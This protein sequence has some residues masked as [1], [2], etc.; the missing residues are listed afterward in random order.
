MAGQLRV[1]EPPRNIRVLGEGMMMSV[2]GRFRLGP[3]P[4]DAVDAHD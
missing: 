4:D 1:E 2:T 3:D